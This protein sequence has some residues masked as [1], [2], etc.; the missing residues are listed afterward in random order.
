MTAIPPAP[1]EGELKKEEPKQDEVESTSAES[2]ALPVSP[3]TMPLLRHTE[4]SVNSPRTSE[5]S[6]HSPRTSGK[7]VHSPRTSEKSVH[8]PLAGST[9]RVLSPMTG[10]G[11]GNY[12]GG[13][14]F[15]A[16]SGSTTKIVS[17]KSSFNNY[18]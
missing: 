15:A 3:L 1:I 13:S 8:S 4:R 17:P 12:H 5:R 16:G 6:V 9:E 10:T 18:G 7:G 2:Q 11:L 14:P